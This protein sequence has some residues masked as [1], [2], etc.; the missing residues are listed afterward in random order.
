MVNRAD[1]QDEMPRE[2][3]TLSAAQKQEGFAVLMQRLEAH[4]DMRRTLL[5]RRAERAMEGYEVSARGQELLD[6]GLY[7]A[8]VPHLQFAA[9]HGVPGAEQTVIE[10]ERA[11]DRAPKTGFG[12]DPS[13][14]R[15]WFV[16]ENPAEPESE[17]SSW[18]SIE[19]AWAGDQGPADRRR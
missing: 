14:P 4:S 19:Q 1:H 5:R 6:Q 7:H 13:A 16:E 11:R 18:D 3:I 9:N 17:P 8:A 15:E 2:R 10:A 12:I